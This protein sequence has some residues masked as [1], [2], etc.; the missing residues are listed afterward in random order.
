MQNECVTS[1]FPDFRLVG[2]QSSVSFLSRSVRKCIEGKVLI[3]RLKICLYLLSQ[4]RQVLEEAELLDSRISA[5]EEDLD[6]V[7]TSDEED[8]EEEK[9]IEH[10]MLTIHSCLYYKCKKLIVCCDLILGSVAGE[11]AIP[12]ATQEGLQRY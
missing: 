12:R 6:E 1:S 9:V 11:S 3:I 7:E 10:T 2:L 8:E 4:K 5:L